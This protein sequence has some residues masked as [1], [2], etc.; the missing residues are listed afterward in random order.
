MMKIL[1][2]TSRKD[3]RLR[4]RRDQ[5]S[6]SP[7]DTVRTTLLSQNSTSEM[8]RMEMYV[9]NDVSHVTLPGHVM[10]DSFVKTHAE[11]ALLCI[12]DKLT[13]LCRTGH[14]VVRSLTTC[15][16]ADTCRSEKTS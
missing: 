8:Y 12:I 3:C 16:K 5:E 13:N 2:A 15:M 4:I 9:S 1:S 11:E 10:P 7:V 6:L 14:C